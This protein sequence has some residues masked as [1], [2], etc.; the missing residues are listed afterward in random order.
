MKRL[1]IGLIGLGTVGGGVVEI[2][3]AHTD[4]FRRRAGVDLKLLRVA[5]RSKERFEAYGL[6]PAC[7]GTDA[8]AVAQDSEIDIV[9][10]LIGGTGI[11]YE[12]VKT[13]LEAGKSVVTANKALMATSGHELLQLAEEKGAELRF[14]GSVGGGIPII[15]ALKHALIS[16]EISSVLGIVNGTTN[17]MLTR[18][19]EDGLDY[20]TA[21][22]EA[23][24]KGYAEADPSADVEG[25]DAA[26][27]IAILASIAFNS[28]VTLDD[29]YTEGISALSPIDIAYADQIGYTVKLLAIA[30]RTPDGIDVRVHP[31]MIPKT[32]Q[33]ASV[34]G[35]YNA[36]Y[37][38]GD[39][40]GDLMFF[41][42]G[43]GAGAA[44]SAVVGD[45][46]EVARARQDGNTVVG[47]T[48]SDNL[49]LRGIDKLESCYYLRMIVDDKSGVLSQMTSVF[50][51]Y[52][53]S[54]KSI[55]QQGNAFE[56]TA[57]I[58]YVTH[59]AHEAA[60]RNVIAELKILPVVKEIAAFLHVEDIS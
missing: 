47:C 21:L 25:F 49:P 40:V 12:V 42:E 1:T 3:K 39:A 28:T 38:T 13:A 23:Q 22:A 33:L 43:A 51:D 8:L 45:I 4:D 56:G 32:H 34:T 6:A 60:I 36:I 57:E 14:E 35:V 55:V 9:V 15:E 44:A 19:T 58:I 37:V 31:T 52:A 50:S 11:A 17:Y 53:V 10:E 24:A 29:V 16:N 26:A 2:L 46:I 30:H 54:V 48:C 7:C 59:R 20:A 5:T 27:K 18:M 41:G